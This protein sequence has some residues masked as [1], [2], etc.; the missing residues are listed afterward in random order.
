[1]YDKKSFYLVTVITLFFLFFVQP[2]SASPASSISLSPLN[3]NVAP[4]ENFSLSVMLNPSSNQISAVDLHINYN[5]PS[6]NLKLNSVTLGSF[7]QALPLSCSGQFRSAACIDNTGGTAE[8]VMGAS[9]GT[10]FSTNGSIATLNFTALTPAATTNAAVDLTGST[11]SA[12]NETAN[13]I[14]SYTGANVSITIPG[15]VT[16]IP[17]NAPTVI[18]SIIP[19]ISSIITQQSPPNENNARKKGEVIVKINSSADDVNEDGVG[20]ISVI[21]NLTDKRLWIGTA[22]NKDASFTGLRFTN[23]TIPRGAKIVS[24]SLEGFN[25][26]FQWSRCRVLTKGVLSPNPLSF[27][28]SNLP[29]TQTLTNASS[30]RFCGFIL[31]WIGR[32]YQNLANVTSIVQ[33][34]VNQGSWQNGN[35]MAFVM[36]GLGDGLH[37]KYIVSFDGDPA[38]APQ[39]LIKYR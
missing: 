23:V 28:Q 10:S 35:S 33:E 22:T 14:V 2:L 12:L 8:V 6:V 30:E 16:S 29:S 11:A 20:G 32:K 25:E 9:P 39:L 7:F 34:L 24:T 27:S 18:T 1:M 21:F 4:G 19:T 31:P 15:S 13:V 26:R 36:K 38:R 3:K 37:R 17:S 5:K